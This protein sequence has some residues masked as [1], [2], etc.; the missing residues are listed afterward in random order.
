LV[1]AFAADVTW[2]TRRDMQFAAEINGRPPMQPC[3]AIAAKAV[4]DDAFE[5]ERQLRDSTT[6]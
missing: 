4:T 3:F 2:A 5:P 1:R 6:G